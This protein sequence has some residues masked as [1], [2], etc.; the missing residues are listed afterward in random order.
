[1]TIQE[2][3]IEL[4]QAADKL[5]SSAYSDLLPE[6]RDYFLNEAITRYVKTNYSGNNTLNASF[7]QIQ[8]RTDDLKTLVK[9]E[10][11]S[12]STVSTETS[13]YKADLSTIYLDEALSSLSTDKYWFYLRGRAR[14]VKAGCTS[15][16][17]SVI[18]YQHDDLDE[19]IHDPFKKSC[20]Q[21]LVGY[22]EN[23]YLYM[24]SPEGYTIDKCKL[25]FLKKPIEVRYGSVY[26]TPVSN[27]D[28][29]LPEHTHK[30]II[31]TAVIIMM[32]NLESPRLQTAVAMKQ[33]ME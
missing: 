23:N 33:T 2:M 1:M 13:I 30:E 17:V 5:A 18:I 9:T 16:Y 32:E 19:V 11:P 21:E 15:T 24:I 22:F 20:T 7:E 12:I 10:F 28:C 26:P 31:Q 4:S 25:T 6:Q 27:I 8:K 29:D 14:L 3:H